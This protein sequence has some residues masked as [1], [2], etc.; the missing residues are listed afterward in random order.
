MEVIGLK[1]GYLLATF[2]A[3]AAAIVRENKKDSFTN[4]SDK[5]T[6]AIPGKRLS[7]LP[8]LRASKMIL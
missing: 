8:G 5:S 6:P 3:E 1:L 7:L 2:E 4:L